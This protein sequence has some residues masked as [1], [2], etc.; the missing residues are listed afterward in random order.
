[1]SGALEKKPQTGLQISTYY[2]RRKKLF[3][4]SVTPWFRVIN[5]GAAV[6]KDNFI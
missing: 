1:M 2:I 4:I 5:Y 6:A 3:D